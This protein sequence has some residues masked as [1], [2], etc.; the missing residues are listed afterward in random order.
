M[1]KYFED[2]ENT[3]ELGIRVILII[4]FLIHKQRHKSTLCVL[5]PRASFCWGET[6]VTV[7]WCP[8]APAGCSRGSSSPPLEMG[9]LQALMP[10]SLVSEEQVACAHVSR[11]QGE[12]RMLDVRTFRAALFTQ[13][14]S[15][16]HPSGSKHQHFIS[17]HS[18]W[19]KKCRFWIW[20]NPER[21]IFLY[22]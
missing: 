7:R 9:T 17:L 4:K 5:D 2:P 3:S 13:K 10:Q 22:N 12:R 16:L 1:L 20:Q 21:S 11:H 18:I 8:Q 19:K 6:P 15:G 14:S